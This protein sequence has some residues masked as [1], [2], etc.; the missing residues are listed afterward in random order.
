MDLLVLVFE[1]SKVSIASNGVGVIYTTGEKVHH[2]KNT[3]QKDSHFVEKIDFEPGKNDTIYLITDGYKKQL[4]T[5]A[6]KKFGSSRL[7]ELIENVSTESL[8][9]QKKHFENTLRNWSEGHDQTDDIT[10]IGLR[11]FNL[12]V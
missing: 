6:G 1:N 10:V 8:V 3:I 4:G 11:N 12:P 7:V 5:L 2:L 9:L